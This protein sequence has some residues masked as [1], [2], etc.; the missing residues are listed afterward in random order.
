MHIGTILCTIFPFLAHSDFTDLFQEDQIKNTTDK[1]YDTSKKTKAEI[2]EKIQSTFER[3]PY[4]GKSQNNN[5]VHEIKAEDIV[6]KNSELIAKI[7]Q[8]LLL[9][10]DEFK[11]INSK[12]QETESISP[13]EKVLLSNNSA[14][15]ESESEWEYEDEDWEDDQP[16]LIPEMLY[17]NSRYS[18]EK[19]YDP[20]CQERCLNMEPPNLA[21]WKQIHSWVGKMGD[22]NN[23]NTIGK[24]F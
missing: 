24:S 16:M 23:N 6:A 5:D 13:A 7:H 19:M 10:A 20:Y 12:N 15:E 1:E 4:L 17:M 21:I 11:N 14:S 3:D 9:N 8:E 2:N 22:S 18:K